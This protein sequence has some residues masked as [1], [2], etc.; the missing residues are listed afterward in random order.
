MNVLYGIL[1]IF[2]D[3]WKK[4]QGSQQGNT[5]DS[6]MEDNL[7][8]AWS[9]V[10]LGRE[11]CMKNKNQ[12]MYFRYHSEV[13]AW[14]NE[15]LSMVLC[16]NPDVTH[17]FGSSCP[18]RGQ[19]M[20]DWRDGLGWVKIRRELVSWYLW[21]WERVPG[22]ACRQGKLSGCDHYCFLMPKLSG[23]QLGCGRAYQTHQGH[24]NRVSMKKSI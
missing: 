10:S 12:R 16:E 14:K 11:I 7:R 20:R 15:K 5:R 4:C 3:F 23:Y 13:R 6:E 17:S 2:R 24:E 8:R 19:L 21:C 9:L 18:G 22:W 1:D